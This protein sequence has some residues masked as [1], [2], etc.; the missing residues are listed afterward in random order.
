MS[1]NIC[2]V[3][4]CLWQ[5][6]YLTG[7]SRG[8]VMCTSPLAAKNGGQRGHNGGTTEPSDNVQPGRPDLPKAFEVR[9]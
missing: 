7:G 5:D 2:V 6:I 9:E 4:L 3:L 8:M 1:H